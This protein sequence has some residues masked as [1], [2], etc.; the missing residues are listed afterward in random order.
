MRIGFIGLGRMGGNMVRRLVRDGHEIVVYN[1]TPEK[2][3][4][5]AAEGA[6]PSF[7]IEEISKPLASYGLEGSTV[8]SPHTC[9]NIASGLWLWVCPPE[10]PPPVGILTTSGQVNWPFER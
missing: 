3:K 9:V 10:I 8:R 4:E 6:T 2:T 7:S 5:F 1:R